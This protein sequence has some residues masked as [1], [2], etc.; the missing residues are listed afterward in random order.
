MDQGIIIDVKVEM[1][2]LYTILLSISLLMMT[3]SSSSQHPLEGIW[4]GILVQN[5]NDWSKSYILWLELDIDGDQVTGYCRDET[6]FTN[7]FALKRI[8]GTV[9]SDTT[10]NYEQYLISKKKNAISKYWCLSS[11]ELRYNTQTGYLSGDWA[12]SDCRGTKGKV[13]F[14]R[15]KYDMSHGDT[16]TLSHQWRND[17][18]TDVNAGRKAP[19]IRQ[20]ELENFKFQPIY[21][22]YDEFFIREEYK[23][24]LMKM[25]EIV[26]GH[27]DLRIKIIGHTDSDGSH[28][29]NDDLSKDR[30]ETV[31]A[32]FLELGLKPH[33]VTIEYRGKKDPVSDNSTSE[34]KQMNRRV[35]FEFI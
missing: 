27:T 17:M 33:K 31:K 11:A 21:F 1:R 34:G 24:Y 18:V 20:K 8:R 5:G 25:A 12:S 13:I 10:L 6:P 4:Q 23:E 14:Y 35:D 3:F 28:E 2:N 15:S 16:A 19:E 22:D 30:A 9:T 32:F 26:D 29:Y 7:Y